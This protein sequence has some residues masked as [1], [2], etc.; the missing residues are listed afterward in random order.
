MAIIGAVAASAGG[1]VALIRKEPEEDPILFESARLTDLQGVPRKLSD[2]KGK[3][4]VVNFWATWCEPCREEIP[5]LVAVREMLHPSGVEFVGI[6]IDQAAKVAQF[7]DKIPITYPVLVADGTGIDL[8]RALGNVR[9]GL[10]FTVVIRRDGAVAYR[11]VG[12]LTKAMIEQQLRT[13]L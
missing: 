7:V 1:L 3:I 11:H 10:P 5:A 6:A 13:L 9:G 12:A 4:L 8:S 2:W